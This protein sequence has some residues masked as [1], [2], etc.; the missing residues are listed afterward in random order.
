MNILAVYFFWDFPLRSLGI[1]TGLT[2]PIASGV[3][4]HGIK[5]T[6]VKHISYSIDN[7]K[8]HSTYHWVKFIYPFKIWEGIN[9]NNCTLGQVIFNCKKMMIFLSYTLASQTPR[10]WLNNQQMIINFTTEGKHACPTKKLST[11]DQD[12][13]TICVC[14]ASKY[15]NQLTH[16]KHQM[17]DEQ[18]PGVFID[19]HVF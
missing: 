19:F 12:D 14:V 18:S 6:N 17:R 11:I 7:Q 3:S 15:H 2:Y 4:K 13:V 9:K 8:S 1:I 10:I 16:R 5:C